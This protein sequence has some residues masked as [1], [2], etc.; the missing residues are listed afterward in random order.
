MIAFTL[1]AVGSFVYAITAYAGY[2]AVRD[3]ATHANARHDAMET[4]LLVERTMGLLVDLETGQRGFMLSGQD[5][6]L[7]PFTSARQNLLTVYPQMVAQMATSGSPGVQALKPVIDELV[8]QRIAAAD[9]AIETRRRFGPD[10]HREMVEH[11]HG[12]ALMDGLRARF[13]SLEAF[14][15][16]EVDRRSRDSDDLSSTTSAV[17]AVMTAGGTL[18]MLSALGLMRYERR[19]RD[20]AD[21]RVRRATEQLEQTVA[22]R[23][24]AL[25]EAMQQ[26]Q[27]F[28]A[29]LDQ[30]IEEER[31]RLAREVHDQLGQLATV[32]KMI[33]KELPRSHPALPEAAIEPLTEL[34][35]ET[36]ETSR[37]ISAELRPPMLDDLGLSAAVQHHLKNVAAVGHLDTGTDVEDDDVLSA[38]QSN[39]LFRI[40]QEAT[41]NVLR[42]AGARRIDVRGRSE[43]LQYH[44]EVADDGRGPQH[45][46]PDASGIRNMKERAALVGGSLQFSPRPEGGT[47]VVVH[48]PI[49]ERAA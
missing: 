9:S 3:M 14:Q 45:I 12:K 22:Q 16:A 24:S 43:G 13:A 21:R 31:R 10:A 7:E 28:T 27:S 42:H 33:A 40:L 8:R 19:Q 48:L 34:L 36:I 35:D 2:R 38:A 17:V 1:I 15:A 18:L 25:S 37:R 6:F 11:L 39:Q 41:T 44:F 29:Q 5:E 23:T 20:R 46:R 4:L 32:A 30:R 26:V 47:S 49:D